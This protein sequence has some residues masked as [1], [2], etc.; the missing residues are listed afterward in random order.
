MLCPFVL[1]EEQVTVKFKWSKTKYLFEFL[2]AFKG[3]GGGLHKI[4]VQWGFW[5]KYQCSMYVYIP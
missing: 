3:L 5:T 1:R 4:N 2:G